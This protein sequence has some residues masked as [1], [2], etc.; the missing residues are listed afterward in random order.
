MKRLDRAFAGLVLTALLWAGC[1][2]QRETGLPEDLVSVIDSFYR[3]IETGDSETHAKM[4]D[5]D[6][7]MMPNHW[8]M[9]RGKEE[10]GEVVRAGK[11]A[12]F[13]IKDR[14]LVE[15]RADGSLAYTVN[16]YHYTYHEVGGSPQ[17]H[18]TKNVHVW[19]KG[20]DGAWK[21][22]IDIWNSDVPLNQFENEN[23]IE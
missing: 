3:A 13:R 8:T 15:G 12:V 10:I 20:A 18:K 6:G 11:D 17:W 23:V 14:K 1:E 19:R 2:P 21:L 4:F 7:M 5:E 9:F 16:S 22:H